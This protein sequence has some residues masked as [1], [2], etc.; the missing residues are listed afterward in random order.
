[1]SLL[2][3]SNLTKPQVAGNPRVGTALIGLVGVWTNNPTDYTCGW[4]R[5]DS[6]GVDCQPITG[7]VA[8][9]YTPSADDLGHRLVVS[10]SATNSQGPAP[11][12][13]SGPSD[14]VSPPVPPPPPKPNSAFA[15]LTTNVAT[16]GSVTVRVSVV[17]PGT[18]T[19]TA[20]ASSAA[21]TGCRHRCRP[22]TYGTGS[23]TPHA[24][25]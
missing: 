21:L 14:P 9:T 7:A 5:C 1:A 8:R 16:T 18:L 6:N 20:T 3:P 13:D 2:R 24:A 17:N 4:M 22:A 15:I 23:R 12:V 10:V 11:P 19:A 25:R